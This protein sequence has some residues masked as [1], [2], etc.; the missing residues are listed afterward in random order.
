MYSLKN[1]LIKIS[2]SIAFGYITYGFR[3]SLALTTC[4]FT[5]WKKSQMFEIEWKRKKRC[6]F[7]PVVYMI[8]WALSDATSQIISPRLNVLYRHSFS[9]NWNSRRLRFELLILEKSLFCMIWNCL[10][11]YIHKILMIGNMSVV[12][13]GRIEAIVNKS[14]TCTNVDSACTVIKAHNRPSDSAYF[15]SSRNS[16][17]FCSIHV[18]QYCTLFS[19]VKCG[20]RSVLIMSLFI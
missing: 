18:H 20:N 9:I 8:R 16:V 1:K 14:L 19:T 10:F 11:M 7:Y 5:F 17:A 15:S 2:S 6:F 13:G 12:L 4:W 3:V